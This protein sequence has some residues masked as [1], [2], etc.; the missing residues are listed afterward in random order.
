L[1]VASDIGWVQC[2]YRHFPAPD[3]M[4]YSL[5]A[6][7]IL[8][9]IGPMA[10][11]VAWPWWQKLTASATLQQDD[12]DPGAETARRFAEA[13]GWTQELDRG[14]AILQ[15]LSK[16][17]PS[18]RA[19]TPVDA[20][21]GEKV[22]FYAGTAP[23]GGTNDLRTDEGFYLRIVNA[24]GKDLRPHA[25]LCGVLVC[26]EIM[27]VLPDNKIIVLEINDPDWLVLETL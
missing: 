2:D 15:K 11:A 13:R 25:I 9:A 4:R 5:R 12:D 20:Y 16:L 18:Q 23:P 17:T 10:L 6:L 24:S 21:R 26:G 8:L 27:Q 3:Q 22:A 1:A 19:A 7:L 14:T